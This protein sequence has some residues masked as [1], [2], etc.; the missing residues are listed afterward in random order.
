MGDCSF[1]AD[2]HCQAT[3][4]QLAGSRM[5]THENEE[6]TYQRWIL[7]P[8][9]QKNEIKCC[10]LTFFLRN[11]TGSRSRNAI[12]SFRARQ[13][14]W[15]EVNPSIFASS[16]NSRS[17]HDDRVGFLWEVSVGM[18]CFLHRNCNS[19]IFYVFWP[20]REGA[21]WGNSDHGFWTRVIND[22]PILDI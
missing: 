10:T 8:F 9:G 20:P 6:E 17:V 21:F 16:W 13:Q 19:S 18:K 1:D 11:R 12:V 22:L 5:C 14:P 4:I 15:V 7:R 3:V 2:G